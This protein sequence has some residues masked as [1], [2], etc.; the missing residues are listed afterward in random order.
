MN[1]PEGVIKTVNAGAGEAVWAM[2]ER[3]TIK[4]GAGD[5]GGRFTLVEMT[6]Q[7]HNGPPPHLHQRED[8]V[9]YVLDGKFEFVVRE[10]SFRRGAGFAHF[11]SKGVPHTYNNI[12]QSPGRLLLLTAPSG[13]E[14]FLQAWSHPV[15]DSSH[16]P[17]A[18]TQQ[19][20][21]RLLAA[22]PRFGVELCADVKS[23]PD[24]GPLST[25]TSYWVMGQF[26]T[27][28]LTA[29]DTAG[30][31]SVAEVSCP[32]GS[33]VLKHL[34]VAMDEVFYVLRGAIEFDFQG[35]SEHVSAGGIV[36]VP[37]GQLHGFRNAGE[38]LASLL[39]IHTPGGFE[40][41]FREAGVPATDVSKPL[42]GTPPGKTSDVLALL[43]KHGMEIP[44][45]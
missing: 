35:G 23:V 7:P 34:H 42:T 29:P 3:M 2:G 43:R 1:C 6:A 24:D 20:I 22:G 13:F 14:R 28:K 4:L 36:F 38:H 19:D 41:F 37:R 9:F 40:E 25:E 32:P 26:V 10:K 31:F 17:P 8:E 16:A 15:Q 44:E 30:L 18:P 21:N 11:V 5:T 39:D 12:G 33:G 27:L 45:A